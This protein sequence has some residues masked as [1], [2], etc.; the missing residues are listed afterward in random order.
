MQ[1][2]RRTLILAIPVHN[3]HLSVEMTRLA[4]R[5]SGVRYGTC[6]IRYRRALALGVAFG[7]ELA[8][9]LAGLVAKV[10]PDA[11]VEVAER[12]YG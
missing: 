3:P 7:Y 10:L 5:A 2:P 8:L 11:T 12:M 9:R 1:A 4:R 6:G